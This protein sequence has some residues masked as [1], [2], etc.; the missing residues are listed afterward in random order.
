[1]GKIHLGEIPKE[2]QHTFAGYWCTFGVD[3]VLG[4][5]EGPFL[6][7]RIKVP[8]EAS[9]VY[10]SATEITI[11]THIPRAWTVDGQPIH[12]EGGHDVL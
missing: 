4:V 12:D 10:R 11:L 3:G 2:Q 6:G 1:M 8:G 7:G 9:P 5:Y